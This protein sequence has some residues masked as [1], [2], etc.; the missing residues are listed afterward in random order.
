MLQ[1]SSQANFM[2]FFYINH[3]SIILLYKSF[4]S[5]FLYYFVIV[6]FHTTIEKRVEHWNSNFYPPH[7]QNTRSSWLKKQKT[8][9]ATTTT[10]YISW[11]Y[12]FLYFCCLKR[13]SHFPFCFMFKFF[14]SNA[15]THTNTLSQWSKVHEVRSLG[16]NKRQT[17]T[18]PTESKKQ[19]TRHKQTTEQRI[20]EK[21]NIQHRKEIY[22]FYNNV[23][24]CCCVVCWW[25]TLIWAKNWM[26]RKYIKYLSWFQWFDRTCVSLLGAK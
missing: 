21:K 17:T 4:V 19:N 8:T 6:L 20:Q 3:F 15:Y 22:F 26:K 25:E 13:Y 7:I 18:T 1:H 11:F 12:I 2:F 24:C 10:Q 9:T 14:L 23:S 16:R 5:L